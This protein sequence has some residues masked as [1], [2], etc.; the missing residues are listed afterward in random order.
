MRVFGRAHYRPPRRGG[1]CGR[2]LHAPP[3]GLQVPTAGWKWRTC[4]S[5]EGRRS[6]GRLAMGAACTCQLATSTH[7]SLEGC[8][9]GEGCC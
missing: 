5:P 3:S 2:G 6:P 4:S 1:R 8:C 7:A 9:S